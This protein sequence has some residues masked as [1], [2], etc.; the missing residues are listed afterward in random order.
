MKSMLNKLLYM[1]FLAFLPLFY[2]AALADTRVQNE[3]K[4]SV[5]S[6][7]IAPWG[8]D[9]DM[10]LKNVSPGDDFFRFANGHWLQ[11]VQ[12]AP[13]EWSVGA[14]REVQERTR[15]LTSDLIDDILHRDWP[16]DSD[17]AKFVALYTSYTNRRAVSRLGAAPLRPFLR[18]IN[19]AKTHTHIGEILGS[20]KVGI[21]GLFHIAI[22]IDPE[23]ERAYLPSLEPDDLLL[24]RPLVYLRDEPAFQARREAGRD[25]LKVLL[26]QSGQRRNLSDRVAAIVELETRIAQLYPDPLAARD[27]TR[28]RVFVS[29]EHLNSLAPDFP[30]T[31][32]F[33]AHLIYEPDRVH[34]RLG[35]NF[36]ALTDVFRATPVSVWRDYLRLRLMFQY[37]DLL[38][39]RI[40][41][42]A[43]ALDALRRGTE[44][45]RPAVSERAR[46]LVLQLM[47]DVVA[48]AYLEEGGPV[49]QISAVE[50]IAEAVGAA[51]RQR[52]ERASW[53]SVETRT[54]ALTKLE[55]VAF[56]I[57]GPSGWNE[58]T[59]YQPRKDRL[60]AN[61]YTARQQRLESSISRLHR[62]TDVPREG[63]D[64]LRERV[65][66][67]PLQTGA[68]YL[69]RL[70]MVIIPANY[71]QA[72]FYD[73]QADMAVNF[74]ALGSTLGHELGHA[75]DDQGS[76][77]G[78][79]GQLENWWSPADR[80]DFDRLGAQLS[81]QFSTYQA[82]P[83]INVNGK[84]TLGENL[85]D[86]V[87][88][89]IAY[90]AYES[91]R[92]AKGGLGISREEGIRRFLR[93]YAQKRRSHRR[94]NVALE[95]ALAGV[96][97]PP[98]HRV[99]GIVRNLDFWYE[100]YD[101][102]PEHDLWLAPED[103]VTVW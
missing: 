28:D 31:E 82:A 63:I 1:C 11:T 52:L 76:K 90:E 7:E 30:W 53:L 100:A 45:M 62:Q 46:R 56:Q 37:G 5:S 88:L 48:R 67:S 80:A 95:L 64:V 86:L 49:S 12:I 89:Q 3:D 77:Y 41:E 103:R 21:G 66:F 6:P 97:S 42:P 81:D 57:G 33:A 22:R 32:F 13:D 47:P 61:V 94:D 85:S 36:G 10:G 68:Y 18:I 91:L 8:V 29:F 25:L 24:G 96:H 2:E 15:A 51:F 92:L 34:V 102:T 17:E 73:P 60:F 69:P 65:F 27:A 79:E 19:Q 44:Y 39:D 38:P 93:G 83:G 87:G 23:G 59:D 4:A 43:E 14:Q 70:N 71:L 58:F 26:R 35:E 101:V 54:K 99:N 40:A 9:L 20:Y 74:G 55:A 78:P 98:E 50:E 16:E 84:L 72:P 75:F